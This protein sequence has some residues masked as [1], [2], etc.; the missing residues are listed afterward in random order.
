MQSP[1]RHAGG[2][3]MDTAILSS[4]SALLGALAG[5]VASLGAAVYT[6]RRQ[7]H[8]QRVAREIAKRETVYAEFVMAASTVLLNA[9]VEHGLT[10]G[11]DQQ[12]LVGILHRI[13]LFA[14]PYV[15]Q[16]AEKVLDS[17]IEIALTPGV[18][19]RQLKAADLDHSQPDMLAKFSKVCRKDLD[20]LHQH[21]R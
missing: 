8:F 1:M 7:D 21:V 20:D 9:Y 4:L 13:R 17:I 14:P 2:A 15:V 3:L 11:R 16:E 5:G 19:P 10:L 12:Q 18:D 6:Q